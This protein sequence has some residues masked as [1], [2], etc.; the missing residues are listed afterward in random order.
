MAFSTEY[1]AWSVSVPVA[2]SVVVVVEDGLSRFIEES[3]DVILFSPLMMFVVMDVNGWR[4][5]LN[6]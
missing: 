1:S 4:V 3:E 6:L 2:C 5:L